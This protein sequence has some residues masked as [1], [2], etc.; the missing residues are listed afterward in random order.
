VKRALAAVFLAAVAAAAA[1]ISVRATY[2]GHA[3]VDEPQYLLTALSLAEDHN[4]DIADEL[5]AR[6]WRAFH[7]AELPVQTAVRA[8]GRQLSPHD[9]LLPALLAVPMAAGGWVAAKAGLALLAGATAALLLWVAVRRFDVP[10]PLATAGAGVAAASPPLAVYG[11]QVYPELPAA[12]AVLIAVAAVTGPLGRRGMAAGGLAIVALPWLSVKYV[13]VAAALAL[14]GLLRLGRAGRWPAALVLAGGL[15]LAG[16]GYL[17]AHRLIWGGWTAYA[18]GDHFLASGEFGV[19]GVQPDYVGRSLRLVG[20]LVDRGFGLAAWAPA[21]LLV[22]PALAG[23]LRRRPP[24]TAALVLPLLAGWLV[25]TFAAL[26]MHGFWWPGRQVVVVLPLAVL[27][28]LWWLA[29]VG[30]TTLAIAAAAG[31]AGVIA[32]AALLLDGW[33]GK[34]TWVVGFEAVDDPIYQAWRVL[35]PD[36]RGAGPALWV[37]HAAWLAAVAALAWWGWRSCQGPRPAANAPSR[38]VTNV[39]HDSE[40]AHL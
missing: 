4:L 31:L 22:V 35:L 32:Y 20:L 23:L 34:L 9:P 40:G 27:I 21:A 36:Y 37:R 3:A 38:C 11:Q 19:V 2:G 25:A 13:P 30:R 8:D 15:G 5:A 28:L 33:A 16:C 24:G 26:T 18:A 1:G 39:V 17:G 7:D 6:R 14:V 10:L 29:R 12:L